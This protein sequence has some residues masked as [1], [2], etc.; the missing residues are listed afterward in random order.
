MEYSN[1]FSFAT[2]YM[3]DSEYIL[4][5]GKPD[6]GIIF[7]DTDKALI[8]FSVFWL[9]FSVFWEVTALS[10]GAPGFFALFGLPFV[11]IGVYMLIGR[12][13]ADARRRAKTAYVV[14][15][16]KIIRLS[17]NKIDILDGKQMPPMHVEIHKNGNGTI[18]F[19]QNHIQNHGAYGYGT[20]YINMS[21]SF[22]SIENIPDYVRVQQAILSMDK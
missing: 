18:S 16:K 14:T 19:G 11:A 21:N 15:N 22:F 3:T 20:T 17:G 8:P 2:Q 1:E 10:A 12:F 6:S 13:F 4:W 5:K 7:T 9:A